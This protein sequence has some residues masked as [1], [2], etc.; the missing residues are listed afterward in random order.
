MGSSTAP[1]VRICDLLAHAGSEVRLRG[2]L[3]NLRDKGRIL[4]LLLR[5]GSALAQC[6]IAKSDVPEA[7]FDAARALTQESA[8]EVVGT[9]RADARAPGGA[10][11]TVAELR[12]HQVAAPYPITP[13]EHGVAFLMEHRHLWLR[14]RK[15]A[16][17]LRV[18]HQVIKAWRDYLDQQGFYCVDSPIFTP[19]ACEGTSTLFE[20]DYFGEKAYLTQSG[21]LYAEASAMALGRVYCFGPTFRAEK[22]KTRRHLTEFWMLE[23]EM[24]FAGLEEVCA[25]A[26]GLL[27]YTL[28]QVLTHR[29]SELADL[30]RDPAQLERYD[31]PFPRLRYDE[32]AKLLA[33]WQAEGKLE[34]QFTY[35]DDLGAPD[36]TALG[37]HFGVPV[38][39]THWPAAIKAFYMKRDP[40]D[41]TKVLGVDVIAPGAGEVVGGSVREDDLQLL[42]QRIEH[43]RLP[44]AAFQWY[45]DLRRYGSVPHAGFGIGLERSLSWICG[46]EHVRECIPFP[47]TLERI[48]P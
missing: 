47:R 16:A 27:R 28:R 17:L 4:F 32:A 41:P 3:Y 20:T 31:V 33:Q 14:S 39:V 36:E 6:V 26:E 11:L 21:Q 9:V 2:W 38:M 12:V 46:V 45:L 48:Y 5:D 25:L 10:E 23:P 22:S 7:V 37:Q 34:S 19:N 42:Q 43:E 29:R 18:R 1:V 13:K 35:G 40:Q 15:Q 44:Q 24:A 30:E 8:L